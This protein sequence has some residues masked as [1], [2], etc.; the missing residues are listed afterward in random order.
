M[1]KLAFL[2]PLALMASCSTFTW[3]GQGAGLTG[4]QQAR[5]IKDIDAL[6]RNYETEKFWA[7]VRARRDGRINAF[8]NGLTDIQN[9]LDRH[10][11]GYSEFDPA[12]NYATDSNLIEHT[13]KFGIT[14]LA[15]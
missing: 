4:D 5:G 7:G 1:R 8:G 13:G 15:R 3:Q 14:F 2:L 10:L 6:V 9:T 11:F 12:V